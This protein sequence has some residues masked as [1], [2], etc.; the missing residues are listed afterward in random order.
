MAQKRIQPA[1][2]YADQDGNIFDH[3][4]LRML[5]RRGHELALPRPDDLIPLPAGSDVFLLP[6]RRAVGFDPESGNLEELEASAVAAFVCPGYTL[7]GQCAYTTQ[8]GA[9][10]LP[11]LAYGALGYARGQF[12]VCARQVDKDPR[13]DFSSIP[14]ERID[15]GAHQLL[16]SFPGNRLVRHLANCALTY[17]CPAAKNL[18]LGRFEAPLPT[19][20]ACN[21]DCVGCIS[22]QPQDSGFAATQQR[23]S[24]RPRVEE[25]TQVMHRHAAQARK[26]VLS[27]GQGCEGEPLLESRLI[28]DAVHSFRRAHGPG[29]VN[30]NTNGSLPATIE[31]L[32]S[33]GLSSIR[34]SLNSAQED[35]YTAYHRPRGYAFADVLQT[36]RQAKASGL[37]VSLNYFFVPGLSDSEQEFQALQSLIGDCRPDFIQLRNLN[38]D[39]ELYLSILPEWDSPSMGL[40]NFTR[41]LR[42]AFPWLSFGYFNPYLEFTPKAG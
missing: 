16:K 21:A 10:I 1:L 29:T 24:F 37:F 35:W 15:S 31:G 4:E 36:M 11:L 40:K 30:I 42:K 12:W 13:Q 32:A 25:I 8:P 2:V 39:P 27:F 41:R 14:Q 22:S 18:A 19:A 20:Q 38:L 7:T 9:E 26:P 3:P 5:C 34:V 23:I 33:A 28:A 17:C 6:H